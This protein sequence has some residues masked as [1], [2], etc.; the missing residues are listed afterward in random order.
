ME[1]DKCV[2]CGNETEYD[3]T[4]HIY[5]RQYYVEGGGQLC[6]TCWKQIYENNDD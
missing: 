5:N 6:R 3:K 2:M 1:K 4:T